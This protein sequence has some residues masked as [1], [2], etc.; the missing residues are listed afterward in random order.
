MSRE[1]IIVNT[2]TLNEHR[3]FNRNE[4]IKVSLDTVYKDISQDPIII[5]IK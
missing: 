4:I 2:F 1:L 5:I 3:L